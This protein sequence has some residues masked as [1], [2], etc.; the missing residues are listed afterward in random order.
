M[1]MEKGFRATEVFF[2]LL[3]LIL[4]NLFAATITGTVINAATSEPLPGANIFVEEKREIGSSA[5]IEGLFR[6]ENIS[7]GS[8][9]ISAT[10]IGYGKVTHEITID[11]EGGSYSLDYLLY[12]QVL[13]GNEVVVTA[14]KEPRVVKDLPVRTEVITKDDIQLRGA[15]DLYQAFEG[16]PGIRV[17]QQCSNCNFSML[18]AQ[19]L[20]G[21]YAEIVVDGQPVFTELA[22]VY[23]LQQMTSASIEQ[24]EIVKGAG[25]ALYGAGALSAIVNIKTKEPDPIP[26]LNLAL[27]AG[28]NETYSIQFDGTMRK[29]KFA[30][31]Y[32][33][34]LDTKGAVDETGNT[35]PDFVENGNFEDA[36][37]DGFTDRIYS[38]N[39]GAILKT[40][41]YEPF[42]KGSKV[43]LDVNALGEFRK[44]GFIE[45][46]DDPFDP[47]AE[48]IRT[49]RYAVGANYIQNF[50]SGNHFDFKA[51]YVNHYRNATNGAAWD[52]AIEAGV[53]DDDL[54]ITPAGE[55]SLA[56]MGMLEFRSRYFPGPFIAEENLYLLDFL[57]SHPISGLGDVMVGTQYRRSEI[58][59]DINRSGEN[60]A[61][62]ADDVGIFAQVDIRPFTDDLEIV[63]GAR[64]DNHK[65]HDGLTGIDYDVSQ[66]NP[67]IAARYFLTGDVT[68]RA[69]Y[70]TGFRVPYLFAEDLH[71]CASSPRIYKG[72][73]LEPEKASSFSFGADFAPGANEIGFGFF[74]TQIDNKIEFIEPG[75]EREVPAGYDFRWTNVG[76]AAT[77]GSELSVR[78]N[79]LP[80]LSYNANTVYSNSRFDERRDPDDENSDRIPR[81]PEWTAYGELIFKFGKLSLFSGLNF[82]GSMFMDH[83]PEENEE[84]YILE[85]T[86]PF[87]TVNS[88]IT[89][90]I[91][92]NVDIVINAHNL[93]G[94]TQPTRDITDAAYIFAPLIG[95]QISG[96]IRINL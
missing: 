82:T 21:G 44:G 73:D 12:P 95:R 89:Y 76:K 11:D 77:L 39:Y 32:A 27:L 46:F 55:D 86:D 23:G 80:W 29:D 50:D 61:K 49:R 8:W 38:D 15:F 64:F 62:H 91:S 72:D 33:L 14:M 53:L 36:G 9:T 60:D 48:H 75:G 30:V 13:R 25:S 22:G 26:R 67:R 56:S 41:L 5:N 37:P 43:I 78:G 52:K 4:P 2:L 92:R 54:D 3:L 10:A 96:G 51:S 31:A 58:E 34:Q 66:V 7:A 35:D 70:G 81:S 68:L 16:Q 79:P 17:E 65:S 84:L 83:V 47:D 28:E 57:Y 87:V 45:T 1:T 74:Y 85:K 42:G 94:Y 59:Q 63:A 24:V 90:S 71:L 6:I 69:S 20:E 93:F 40:Y 19:G 88:G 18:R